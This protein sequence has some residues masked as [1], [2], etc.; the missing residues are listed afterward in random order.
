VAAFLVLFTGGLL[1]THPI[2]AAA[3]MAGS[4]VIAALVARAMTGARLAPGFVPATAITMVGAAIAIAGRGDADGA[5]LRGGEALLVV[6]VAC[7]TAYSILAQRWFRPEVPQMRRTWLGAVGAIPWLIVAWGAA[8]ATGLIGAPNLAPDAR[9]LVLLGSTAVLSTALSTVLWNIGVSRLGVAA[10]STLAERGAGVRGADLAG[11]LRDRAHR[12]AGA[13]R[14]GG[15]GRRVV[16]AV[17]GDARGEDDGR[18]SGCGRPRGTGRD[19]RHAR[20]VPVR[21]R[22]LPSAAAALHARRPCTTT[23]VDRDC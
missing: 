2:T 6:S 3:V 17:A 10:G 20:V 21:R 7:W 19:R 1:L 18:L 23:P 5:T 13:G 16:P 8:R 4:P 9:S 14:R 15:A 12:R 11:L 22:I